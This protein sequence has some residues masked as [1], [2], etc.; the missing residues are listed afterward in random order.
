MPTALLLLPLLAVAPDVGPDCS[1]VSDAA[2]NIICHDASL[3]GR[4]RELDHLYHT[5]QHSLPGPAARA[6]RARQNAWLAE[7][8]ACAPDPDARNCLASELGQRIVELKLALHQ[9]A[10]FAQATYVCP[11]HEAT[12]LQASYYRTDPGAVRVRYQAQ[13]VLA[14]AA[15]SGSGARY[16]GPG[17]ELWE[18]QGV[19]RLQWH[20]EELECP[21][22]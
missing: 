19:A 15:P 9:V 3:R 18:H 2:Q 20:G 6:E 12:P 7:R 13:E 21:K 1:S 17:V 16:T 22:R 4:E 14:F 10:V 8:A 11:G 5:S